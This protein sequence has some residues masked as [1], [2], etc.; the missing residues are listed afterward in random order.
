MHVK[1]SECNRNNLCV[2]CDD[3]ECWHAGILIADCPLLKCNRE[4]ELFEDCESCEM[5]KRIHSEGR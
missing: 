5:L 1:V 4:G 2:D 3:K